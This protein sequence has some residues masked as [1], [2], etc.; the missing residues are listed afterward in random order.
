MKKKVYSEFIYIIGLFTLTFGNMLMTKSDFGVSMVV[1][2][3]YL[4][5]LKLVETLPFFSFGFAGYVVN[6]LLLVAMCLLLQKF[7][8]TYLFSFITVL[9]YGIILDGYMYL[10]TFI[11]ETIV[12]RILCFV[13]GMIITSFGVACMINTYLAPEVYDLFVR[14]VSSKFGIG[15]SKFKTAYDCTSLVV[16]VLLSFAFFGLWHFEGIKF[17]TLI[18]ALLNGFMIGKWSKS[19]RNFV[20]P[21][22]ILPI[23]KYFD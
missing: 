8:I 23:K 17:G 19:I 2:P 9:F 14:E 20:I 3:A 1:A 16:S 21:C 6:G 13:F 5:H 12:V 11:P 22:H 18:C 15:L 7:K 4:L 10:G